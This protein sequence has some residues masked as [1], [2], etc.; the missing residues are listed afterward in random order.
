MSDKVVIVHLRRP[1]L[2]NPK[3]SRKD[4]FWEFGSFGLTGCHSRNLMHPKRAR[5]LNG[6]R[7]AFVQGGK[8]EMRLVYLS[9]P[10]T[11][12]VH[13]NVAEAR[14]TPSM[15]FA[16]GSAPLVVNRSGETMFP[17]LKR[18]FAKVARD[19]WPRRF[20]S[21]YRSRSIYLPDE[22]AEE[23]ATIFDTAYSIDNDELALTYEEA[24]PFLPR[25]VDRDRART[26]QKL[27]LKAKL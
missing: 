15:P 27:L 6:I 18:T 16:F 19:T 26:Y 9:P 7:L 17:K 12:T 11:S 4:P 8:D 3:D 24:L 14:W 13:K 25:L 1:R 21:M 20:S 5:E 2:N 10:I 22:V 23:V